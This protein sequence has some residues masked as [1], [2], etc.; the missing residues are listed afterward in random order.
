MIYLLVA[1]FGTGSWFQPKV[2]EIDDIVTSNALNQII[3]PL[4]F[5]SSSLCILTKRS[6]VYS[7]IRKEKILML[8]LLWC[9]LSIAWSID[10]LTTSKRLF[11]T[12]TLFTVTLSLLA[13]TTSTKEILS[14]IKPILYLYVFS[15]LVVCLT[16]PGAIDAD[17]QTW[18][19][20]TTTKNSLGQDSVVCILLSFFIFKRETGYQKII[21]AMILF[22]SIALLFGSMS[23]T[24][25]TSFLVVSL[26]GLIFISDTIFE[27]IGLGRKTS[28]IIISFIIGILTFIVFF[29]PIILELIA[30]FAGKNLTFTGRTILWAEMILE[31]SKHL[32]FG[33]GYQA[34]WN[35]N[36]PSLIYLYKIFVWLPN[37]AHNG[38]IDI[39]NETGLVGLIIFFTVLIKYFSNLRKLREPNPWKWLVIATLIINLQESNLFRPGHIVGDFFVIVYFILF[40]QLL[41]Q[42]KTENIEITS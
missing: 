42:E 18:R 22:F 30:N 8:F 19:G 2:E 35:I 17:F 3:F 7:I 33:V 38:Y 23:V 28:L 15:S 1:F 12:L 27:P 39:I 10:P 4:L 14:Y 31:I 34:F 6:K 37:E 25:I 40:S 21:A 32:Y 5:L 16:I 41:R 9:I 24:S 13:H 36:N 29:A 11:R 20:F 26:V